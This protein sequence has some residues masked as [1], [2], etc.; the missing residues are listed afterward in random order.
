VPATARASMALYNLREDVD[1]LLGEYDGRSF[2][3]EE[4]VPIYRWRGRFSLSLEPLGDGLF[5]VEGTEDYR[6]RLARENGT[7]TGVYRDFRDGDPQFYAR[8]N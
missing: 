4:G 6:F 1:A 3:L 2:V 7:V 5:A 8:L